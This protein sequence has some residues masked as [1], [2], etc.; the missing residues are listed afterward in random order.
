MTI[1]FSYKFSGSKKNLYKLNPSFS[2]FFVLIAVTVENAI[3]GLRFLTRP[4][5]Q[6]IIFLIRYIFNG[7]LFCFSTRF[8]SSSV[9]VSHQNGWSLS[10]T[11]ST[12]GSEALAYPLSLKLAH[13]SIWSSVI[14][15]STLIAV[16][17]QFKAP[18]LA[19]S[20]KYSRTRSIP[21][22]PLL[23]L[24][25]QPLESR[26]SLPK[27]AS[28]L[29]LKVSQCSAGFSLT[30]MLVNTLTIQSSLVAIGTVGG[31]CFTRPQSWSIF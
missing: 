10:C 28:I 1:F 9:F 4:F 24:R 7:G 21:N 13:R 2:E 25:S 5:W 16:R 6:C 11:F 19:A 27:S 12:R 20:S 26:S 30:G 18:L 15:L 3:W 29:Q 31:S 14:S 8:F 23:T 17:S 22:A